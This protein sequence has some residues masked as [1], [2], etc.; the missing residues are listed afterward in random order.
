M[1]PFFSPPLPPALLGPA[2]ILGGVGK[3]VQ[4]I[5]SKPQEAGYAETLECVVCMLVACSSPGLSV[6]V[7]DK[8]EDPL[9]NLTL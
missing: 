3:P 5:E 1:G 2:H 8:R 7:R 6:V 9:L 4:W